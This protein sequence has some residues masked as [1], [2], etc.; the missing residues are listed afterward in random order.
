MQSPRAHF[1]WD[2]IVRVGLG[3]AV[4]VEVRYEG[5]YYSKSPPKTHLSKIRQALLQL[6]EGRPQ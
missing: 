1:D 6:E 5:G 4:Y 3:V 2:S